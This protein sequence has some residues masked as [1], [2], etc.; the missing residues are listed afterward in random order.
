[1]R[2]AKKEYLG[3]GHNCGYEGKI[4]KKILQDIIKRNRVI[5]GLGE[6]CAKKVIK[7][8]ELKKKISVCQEE[9]HLLSFIDFKSLIF[10]F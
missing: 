10:F 1:M 2:K 8:T 6:N 9:K 7:T 3:K 5:C 4:R